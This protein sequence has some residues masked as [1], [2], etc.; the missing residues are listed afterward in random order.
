[1]DCI[2]FSYYWPAPQQLLQ[3]RLDHHHQACAPFYAHKFLPV[4]PHHQPHIHTHN[5]TPRSIHLSHLS[6]YP[7]ILPPVPST[8]HPI[9]PP[10]SH[11]LFFTSPHLT[12]HPYHPQSPPP[13]PSSLPSSPIPFLVISTIITITTRYPTLQYTTLPYPTLRTLLP[14]LATP[15]VLYHIDSRPP[16]VTSVSPKLCGR[17]TPGVANPAD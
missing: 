13:P 6:I 14:S 1:M 2:S 4:G 8:P 12:H 7:S 16:K 3:A 10:E 9:P 15:P 17:E 11:S 5:T